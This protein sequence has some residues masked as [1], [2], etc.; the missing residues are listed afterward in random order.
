MRL[1]V[2][3]LLVLLGAC[4]VPRDADIMRDGVRTTRG[5]VAT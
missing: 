3:V 2:L 4:G 5:A 1:V